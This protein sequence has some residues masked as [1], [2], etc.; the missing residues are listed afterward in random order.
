VVGSVCLHA[1][2][3]AAAKLAREANAHKWDSG[4]RTCTRCKEEKP[5]GDFT[6]LA[7][8]CRPCQALSQAEYKARLGEGGRRADADRN[9]R[10]KYGIT[11]VRYEEMLEAQG[12]V[13][14][15]CARE[16]PSGIRLHVDHD[17]RCCPGERSCGECIRGLLCYSCNGKLGLLESNS[18]YARKLKDYA[19]LEVR[20]IE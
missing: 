16:H 11:L 6:K 12:G 15:V 4:V 2:I 7:F 8:Q 19:G 3:N 20:Y 18:D 9:L 13:C 17:H 5:S 10:R 1:C 14:K